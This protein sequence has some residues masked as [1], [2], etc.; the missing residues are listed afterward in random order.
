MNQNKNLA[1]IQSVVWIVLGALA[2]LFFF[3]PLYGGSLYELN[4]IETIDFVSDMDS[5]KIKRYDKLTGFLMVGVPVLALLAGFLGIVFGV[6]GLMSGKP[7]RGV[8]LT[9][10][11][12]IN[13][14]LG[15]VCVVK[16]DGQA[17]GFF[18]VFFPRAITGF[19]V[20]LFLQLCLG[21]LGPLMGMLKRQ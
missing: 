6:A 5:D 19:Y 9:V 18:G 10:L 14:L 20:L 15:V 4:G 3:L 11:A 1:Q 2:V 13:L 12:G 8:A 7:S 21:G 16:L 17:S